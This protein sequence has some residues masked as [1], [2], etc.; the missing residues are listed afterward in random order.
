MDGAAGRVSCVG[1]H[2][3]RDRAVNSTLGA[4]S[5]PRARKPRAVSLFLLEEVLLQAR[6]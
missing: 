2:G 5:E 3:P 1:P 6:H 4:A